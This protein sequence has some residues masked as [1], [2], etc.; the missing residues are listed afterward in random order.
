MDVLDIPEQTIHSAACGDEAAFETI[1]Q[2]FSGFV[3]RVS[4]RMV[5]NASDA[6]EI[7]QDI[8]VRIFHQLEEFRFESSLKT[9]IYRITINTTLNYRKKRSSQN[10]RVKKYQENYS[11]ESQEEKPCYT[12]NEDNKHLVE[13]LL[14]QLNPEQRACI[15]LRNIEG[16]SYEEIAQTLEININTVRT[17]LKR[18]REKLM[19]IGQKVMDHEL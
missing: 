19:A 17:R 13:R 16:L 2:T 6:Q 4:L 12:Q 8:F 14:K 9:W 11:F 7:V 15:V 18:A 1:Y 3:Y 10:E 5:D